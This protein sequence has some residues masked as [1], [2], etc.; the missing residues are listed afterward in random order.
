MRVSRET[1]VE[2]LPTRHGYRHRTFSACA[3]LLLLF[4]LLRFL[5]VGFCFIPFFALACACAC[6]RLLLFAFL[7]TRTFVLNRRHQTKCLII[8]NFVPQVY[9]G[10]RFQKYDCLECEK[11]R[12][13]RQPTPHHHRIA[14]SCRSPLLSCVVLH[15]QDTLLLA[16][17]TT[18]C[19]VYPH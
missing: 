1:S 18:E 7:Q 2:Q 12:V 17:H 6:A 5:S 8:L 13:Y 9:E 10:I 16:L 19:Q 4:L 15:L 3:F 11:H 14:P